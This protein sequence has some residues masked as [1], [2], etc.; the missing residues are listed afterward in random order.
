M[1]TSTDISGLVSSP[2]FSCR[3]IEQLLGLVVSKSWTN[4]NRQ[5]EGQFN[6]RGVRA[7]VGVAASSAHCGPLKLT[8]PLVG[9]HLRCG[10][11]RYLQT[12]LKPRCFPL[13]V[14]PIGTNHLATR[15][16]KHE[17]Y[18]GPYAVH[19]PMYFSGATELSYILAKQVTGCCY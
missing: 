4:S 12:L 7:G 14:A 19:Q 8:A 9:Y 5:N 16:K 1:K 15:I 17:V 10:L 11:L 18:I 3:I 2:A 6:D 13:Q